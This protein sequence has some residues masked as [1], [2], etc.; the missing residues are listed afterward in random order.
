MAPRFDD[1]LNNTAR[2][3]GYEHKITGK[4]G[5]HPIPLA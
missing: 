5:V 1:F 2:G 4:L 3:Y